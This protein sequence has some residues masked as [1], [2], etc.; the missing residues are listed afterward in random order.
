MDV[1]LA[2]SAQKESDALP[3]SLTALKIIDAAN[4]IEIAEVAQ[5]VGSSYHAVSVSV[6]TL[7]RKRFVYKSYGKLHRCRWEPSMPSAL[8]LVQC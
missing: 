3:L 8:E 7:I 4:G 2:L 5:I 1:E 6:S